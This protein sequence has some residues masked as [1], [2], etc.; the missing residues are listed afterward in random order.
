MALVAQPVQVALE[1]LR[2]RADQRRQRL[3]AVFPPAA[4]AALGIGIDEAHRAVAG[5]ARFDS[6]M[7]GQGGLA[8][9][10]LLRSKDDD[11]HSSLLSVALP[12]CPLEDLGRWRCVPPF[13]MVCLF[14]EGQPAPHPA[15]RGSDRGPSCRLQ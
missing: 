3:A 11:L 10:A 7:A 6:E 4:Q 15:C 8:G 12:P 14:Q 5:A 2:G 13:P 9:P 1:L